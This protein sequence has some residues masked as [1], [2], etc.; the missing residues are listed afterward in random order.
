MTEQESVP[1]R[2]ALARAVFSSLSVANYRKY[3]IGQTVSMTGNWM[4]SV[5]NAWLIL[6][7]T[8]SPTWLGVVTALQF[9]PVLVLAPYGGVLVDRADKRRLLMWT[10]AASGIIAL[11]LGL[12]TVTNHVNEVWL[13][14]VAI[15]FGLVN[16]VDNPARQALVREMVPHEQVRNAVTLNSVIANASRAVGPAVAG[17]LIATVGIGVS[18]LVNAVTFLVMIAA[19]AA[20]NPRAMHTL[21]A[22]PREPGQLRQGLAYVKSEFELRT[23]LVMM[24]IVGT[25]TYEFSV[26]LPPLVRSGF[27]GDARQLGWVLTAMGVGAVIGGLVSASRSAAGVR[28]MTVAAAV[29]GGVT[30]IATFMPSVWTLAAVMSLVG[31]ASVWF[32]SVTNA[33]LQ[34]ESRPDMRGRVMSLWTVAF[35]GST[36]IGAPLVGWIGAVLGP[37]CPLGVG[38]LAALVAAGIGWRALETRPHDRDDQRVR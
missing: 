12:V 34:L 36:T 33:T 38:A 32:M 27:E 31:A 20:M 17:V 4:Q 1:Q 21:P 37:R 25:L 7:V 29:F 16:S 23:A 22:V 26:V 35:L 8:D 10:Q 18:F 2:P 30:L 5:S 6:Q 9:L 24:A 15:A 19:L 11:T 14:G 3:F 28:T 13:V